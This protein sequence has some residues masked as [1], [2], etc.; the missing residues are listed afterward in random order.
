VHGEGSRVALHS[1]FTST[2]QGPAADTDEGIVGPPKHWA[3]VLTHLA[4]NIGLSTFVLAAPPDPDTLTTFIEDVAPNVR[5]RVGAGRAETQ[6]GAD[7]IR[8]EI[9]RVPIVS[10][11]DEGTRGV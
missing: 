1:A 9:A 5:D 10:E 11:V 3:E 6:L 7:H 2:R 4:L 8:H